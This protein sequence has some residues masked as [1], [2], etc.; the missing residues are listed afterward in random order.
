MRP[1]D[2]RLNGNP[3]KHSERIVVDEVFDDS[4]VRLMRAKYSAKSPRA[5]IG[6]E[7][8]GTERSQIMEGWRLEAFVGYPTAVRL[9]EGDVFYVRD[10]RKLKPRY[11]PIKRE[12]AAALHLLVGY[13]HSG[14]IAREEIRRGFAKLAMSHAARKEPE[15]RRLLRLVEKVASAKAKAKE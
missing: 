2:I 6:I 10:G 8:W 1:E 5:G 3:T 4:L 15:R 12:R 7:N 14:K 13:E 9:H 11:K